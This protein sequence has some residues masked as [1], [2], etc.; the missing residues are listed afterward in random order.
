MNFVYLHIVLFTVW[1]LFFDSKP[2]PTLTRV[3]RQYCLQAFRDAAETSARWDLARQTRSTML[4]YT[5]S[6]AAF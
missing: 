4:R 2:W 5:A 1:M 3:G 6:S